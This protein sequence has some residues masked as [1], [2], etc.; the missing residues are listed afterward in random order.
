MKTSHFLNRHFPINLCITTY[1]SQSICVENSSV[2]FDTKFGIDHQNESIKG[3][4]TI[5]VATQ[6]K[7][8]IDGVDLQSIAAQSM[9]KLRIAALFHGGE[10]EEP[11]TPQITSS[12]AFG[13]KCKASNISALNN[14]M[15][16]PFMQF[17]SFGTWQHDM[18]DGVVYFLNTNLTKTMF[19]GANL[20]KRII[21]KTSFFKYDKT[22]VRIKQGV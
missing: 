13:K 17:G 18:N 1:K 21:E 22:L 20:R 7:S 4:R 12:S 2:I 10:D 3:D 8:S 14:T 19:V 11:T 9:S 5:V 15:E 16:R 6:Y